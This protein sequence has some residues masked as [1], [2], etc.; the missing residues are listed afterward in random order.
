LLY[1]RVERL[2]T[3]L[4]PPAAQDRG[5]THSRSIQAFTRKLLKDRHKM[6]SKVL[7]RIS[8]QLCGKIVDRHDLQG[9][10]Q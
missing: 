10:T 7:G 9:P 8:G 2:V 3:L 4:Q 6:I 1:A 5:I